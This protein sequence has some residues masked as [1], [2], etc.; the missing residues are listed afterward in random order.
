M[1]LYQMH[2]GVQKYIVPAFCESTFSEI[3]LLQLYYISETIL[4][5]MKIDCF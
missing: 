2:P 1:R 3:D 5:L 4:S